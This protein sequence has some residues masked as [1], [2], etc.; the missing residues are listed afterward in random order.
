LAGEGAKSDSEKLH[1]ITSLDGLY[2]NWFLELLASYVIL[3]RA[4]PHI[5]D[6]LKPFQRIFN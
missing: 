1:N 6:G 3:D 5:Y 4:V 2:E